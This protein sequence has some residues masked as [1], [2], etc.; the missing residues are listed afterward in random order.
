VKMSVIDEKQEAIA[1]IRMAI[2]NDK[3]ARLNSD[4]ALDDDELC[5]IDEH[6]LDSQHWQL[7]YR[8]GKRSNLRVMSAELGRKQEEYRGLDER[9]RDFVA[10]HMQGEA[11]RY[12]DDI[13]VSPST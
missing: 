7:G 6:H 2:D 4:S 10:C 8:E 12:E 1:H 11:L 9:V 5:E 3:L 13:H